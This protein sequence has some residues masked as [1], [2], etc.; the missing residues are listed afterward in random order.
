V[1]DSS[2]TG[3]HP[4]RGRCGRSSREA[5]VVMESSEHRRSVDRGAGT[6]LRRPGRG[7]ERGWPPLID[8]LVRPRGVE[9]GPVLVENALEMAVAQQEDVI[10]AFSP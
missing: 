2:C 10:Q 1:G 4:H 3:Y 7:A 6:E 5:V 8:P 9:V